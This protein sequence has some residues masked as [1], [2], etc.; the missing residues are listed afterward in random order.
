MLDCW[1]S[2]PN[3]RP[4]F[5]ELVKKLGDLLQAN[6]QQVLIS[7]PRA[8]TMAGATGHTVPGITL[9]CLH[10]GRQRLHTPQYDIYNGKRVSPC[11]WSFVQWKFFCYKLK[12]W[13]HWKHQ[14]RWARLRPSLFVGYCSLPHSLVCT[15]MGENPQRHPTWLEHPSSRHH[16]RHPVG[17]GQPR[18]TTRSRGLGAVRGAVRAPGLGNEVLGGVWLTS[19]FCVNHLTRVRQLLKET[20]KYPVLTHFTLSPKTVLLFLFNRYINTFKIKPPQRI[21]TFEEL[22]I[23]ETLIFNVSDSW[24]KWYT[25]HFFLFVWQIY[26]E[27][28]KMRFYCFVSSTDK[29]WKISCACS[30]VLSHCPTNWG[31]QILADQP[32]HGLWTLL[33]W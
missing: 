32:C 27:R 15:W 20:E 2:N 3:D 8:A 21:K 23:K 24:A 28:I 30:I 12:L 13:K 5:S 26:T 14:V 25:I 1:R 17:L 33:P 9:S 19:P 31:Q 29:R 22:P 11:I 18:G 4:R 7:R 6:V 16:H 10:L